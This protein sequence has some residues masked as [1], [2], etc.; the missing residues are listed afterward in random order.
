MKIG[1]EEVDPKH[2][3]TVG[4]LKAFLSDAEKRGSVTDATLVHIM[5]MDNDENETGYAS[6]V[7]IDAFDTPNGGEAE[8][9]IWVVSIM[10]WRQREKFLASV[11]PISASAFVGKS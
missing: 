5:D 7:E 9:C 1:G 11:G 6:A 3:L 10:K 2:L 4:Q 8:P